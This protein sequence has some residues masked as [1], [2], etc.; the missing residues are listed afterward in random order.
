MSSERKNNNLM[1][2]KHVFYNEKSTKKHRETCK[3]QF[4]ININYS[5]FNTW[6][7]NVISGSAGTTTTLA[8]P[9]KRTVGSQ[10]VV[11]LAI[12]YLYS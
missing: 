6:S 3:Q 2:F 8:N 7:E 12:C 10:Y 9:V 4:I 1:V 11:L 5:I